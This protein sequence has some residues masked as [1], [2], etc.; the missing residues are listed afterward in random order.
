MRAITLLTTL[1]SPLQESYCIKHLEI[2]PLHS[3]P[4]RR[5]NCSQFS[6]SNLLSPCGLTSSELAASLLIFSI[7]SGLTLITRRIPDYFQ[8]AIS[9]NK[10]FLFCCRQFMFEARITVQSQFHPLHLRLHCFYWRSQL[11]Y[12]IRCLLFAMTKVTRTLYV[13]FEVSVSIFAID[14]VCTL[15]LYRV[16][17]VILLFLKTNLLLP[18]VTQFSFIIILYYKYSHIENQKSIN[19]LVCK[20][21]FITAPLFP[22]WVLRLGIAIA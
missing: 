2:R 7:Q 5:H 12:T 9:Q 20:F 8:P 13:I 4:L 18:A 17:T 16:E 3:T 14:V 21:F 22:G 6:S 11:N 10:N 1:L 15:W 19:I